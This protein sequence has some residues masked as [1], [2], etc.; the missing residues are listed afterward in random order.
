[1]S[2]SADDS[3][4]VSDQDTLLTADERQVVRDTLA[5]HFAHCGENVVP[6][7]KDDRCAIFEAGIIRYVIDSRRPVVVPKGWDKIEAGGDWEPDPTAAGAARPSDVYDDLTRAVSQRTE[8][9]R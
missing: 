2:L 1:M 5:A 7:A 6:A 8:M 3:R 9:R 4:L